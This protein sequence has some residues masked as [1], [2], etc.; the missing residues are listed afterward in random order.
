MILFPIKYVAHVME[1]EIL[2]MMDILGKFQ[3]TLYL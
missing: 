2:S 1:I 3:K